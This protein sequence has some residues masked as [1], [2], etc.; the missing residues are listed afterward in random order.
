M[1][2][3]GI[4]L[5]SLCLMWKFIRLST[6][7]SHR[8]GR[9]LR[10]SQIFDQALIAAPFFIVA[11]LALSA[12]A[13]AVAIEFSTRVAP[14]FDIT[15]IRAIGGGSWIILALVL[16][17]FAVDRRQLL[18]TI[19]IDE[20]LIALWIVCPLLAA[21]N[22]TD[23]SGASSLR[24]L[25]A[26][27]FLIGSMALWFKLFAARFGASKTAARVT[28]MCL[29]A[30]PIFLLTLWPASITLD[31]D[32]FNG[33]AAGSFF[34]WIGASLSYVIPLVI[35]ALVL[36]GN[37]VTERS[38]GYAFAASVVFC[39]TGSLGY[40]LALAT[41]H[42]PVGGA[43]VVRLLQINALI[44]AAIAAAWLAARDLLARL[45]YSPGAIPT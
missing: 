2:S 21:R 44:L 19:A 11:G 30:F 10:S 6:G 13:V 45:H 26:V 3:V 25:C 15:H 22:A 18:G 7:R 39:F 27:Y 20:I 12:T 34:T 9:T 35:V 24:W 16:V 28:L 17:A 23:G 38:Q 4:A 32:S 37:A 14:S 33:P 43:E 40:L 36:V 8:L 31:G 42:T 41:A 29:G 1:Q 5:A